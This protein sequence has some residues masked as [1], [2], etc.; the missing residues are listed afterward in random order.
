MQLT[1]ILGGGL[2]VA[3]FSLL[4][5]RGDGTGSQPTP[6]VPQQPIA[7]GHYVLV[8]QGDRDQLTVAHANRKADPWAG[9]PKGLQSAWSLHVHGGDG[10]LL[11][12]VP[13]D[14]SAFDLAAERKGGAIEVEGCIV[15]DP[16]IAMLVNV[17]RFAAAASYTFTRREAAGEVTLGVVDGARVRDLAGGDK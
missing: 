10:Q 7:D 15:H 12:S 9:V 3:A 14:V 13:L 4:A 11:V 2:L 8:V 1:H 6:P 16:K 17:P 5:V